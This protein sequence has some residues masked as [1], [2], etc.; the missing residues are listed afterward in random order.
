MSSSAVEAPATAPTPSGP[1]RRTV[2]APVF[3]VILLLGALAAGWYLKEVLADMGT[4]MHLK[5]LG[6]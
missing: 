3:W 4:L 5:D 6:V 2:P 1:G